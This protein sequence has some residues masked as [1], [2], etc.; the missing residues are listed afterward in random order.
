MV[1]ASGARLYP[2]LLRPIVTCEP[3]AVFLLPAFGAL[4]VYCREKDGIEIFSIDKLKDSM[5]CRLVNMFRITALV[6]LRL[7]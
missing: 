6:R 7:D 1:A 4:P 3:L 5:T 2:E